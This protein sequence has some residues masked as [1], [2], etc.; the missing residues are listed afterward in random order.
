MLW[1]SALRARIS[2]AA[3]SLGIVHGQDRTFRDWRPLVGP[4]SVGVLGIGTISLHRALLTPALVGGAL[5]GLVLLSSAYAAMLAS[6]SFDRAGPGALQ[7]ECAY[8]D[9][10]V[11]DNARTKHCW[12]CGEC[13]AG[14]DHHCAFLH[15]CIGER[16]YGRFAVLI[17][18]YAASVLALL[19]WLVR[20]AVPA[21]SGWARGWRALAWLHAA[22][23]GV[24][25]S[26][27]LML[28]ALHGYLMLTRQTTYEVVLAVREWRRRRREALE[29]VRA[30][31]P[32]EP[33][34]P[35]SLRESPVNKPARRRRALRRTSSSLSNNSFSKLGGAIVLP[36]TEGA[37]SDS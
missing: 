19:R 10:A 22:V 5:G 3:A 17:G 1:W 7:R 26:L 31:P 25:A 32:S 4:A 34:S 33:S 24:F 9:R 35:E 11:T 21:S 30:P 28:C 15:R 16:N 29:R 12:E 37:V 6:E 8:C 14:F 20:V 23:A 2:D 18:G 27:I 13:I 36:V